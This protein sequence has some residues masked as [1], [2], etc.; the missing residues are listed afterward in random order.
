[1][2]IQ[3][4]PK[5][6]MLVK[7]SPIFHAIAAVALVSQVSAEAAT[8]AVKTS[9]VKISP[10][11]GTFWNDPGKISTR[12]LYNG[13]GGR[14]REPASGRF[15][16]V[17]EDDG[18]SNPKFTVRD[19][20]GVEWKVKLGDEVRSE[21]AATRFLWA[22]GYF[23]DEDYFL[24][25]IQVVNMPR[26]RR[27]QS[28]VGPAG[29]VRNV[30][31][32]RRPSDAKMV[33]SWKWK[34]SSLKGM[35]ELNGLRVMMTLMNNWDL[36]DSNT[37]VYAQTAGGRIGPERHVYAV[38]DMGAT[39]GSSG[40]SI[41]SRKSDLH[42]FARSRFITKVTPEYVDFASP[43]RPAMLSVFAPPVFVRRMQTRSIGKQIPRQDV[44]W[45]ARLLS[46]LTP[47]QIRSA[48]RAAGYSA[49]EIEG[50]S[51]VME[52]RIAL[53]TEL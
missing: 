11:R 36:K 24:P 2:V 52:T 28:Y 8:S 51:R 22:V 46:Q 27:G 21:T 14:T 42:S 31:L 16:F 4:Q 15:V 53:L 44:K 34:D 19:R 26:L 18:D 41:P 10:A 25:S 50:F 7:S 48:F 49:E 45:I 3:L 1:M 29:V 30:R 20:N 40:Y 17:S 23:C 37:A 6:V 35:R 38:S 13:A 43:G 32:E 12:D 5:V 9:P 39:F 33:D 47:S